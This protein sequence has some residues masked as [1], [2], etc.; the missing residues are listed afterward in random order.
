MRFS[1]K[2]ARLPASKLASTAKK[3]L[4]EL[5]RMRKVT[6]EDERASLLLS[7][8]ADVLRASRKTAAAV[9]RPDVLV[10]IG[11]GGS[12]LG[13]VAVQ[14]AVLGKGHNR[15]VLADMSASA[16]GAG[17]PQGPLVFYADTV[18]ADAIAAITPH[19]KGNVLLNI[20]S[21]SGGTTET[22]ANARILAKACRATIV[23]TTTKDS[24]LWN[25]AHVQGWRALEI[26]PSVGGR[27]SV[28]SNVGI[29]PLQLLGIDVVALRKGAAAMRKQCQLADVDKNPALASALA[30]YLHAQAGRNVTDLFLF[31]NDLESLGKWYRQL[32]G[33]SIGKEHDR[34]GNLVHAGITPTVS[35]GSTDLHSVGQLYLGGP[36]DK[37]VTFVRAQSRTQVMVPEGPEYGA[38]VSNLG[39]KSCQD[40][41][42]AILEGTKA[43]FDSARRPFLEI[44]MD[45]T[46]Q[47]IGAFL[48]FKMMEVMFLG[49]LYGVNPFDQP[50]VE[51]YKEH[52]RELL[53][54]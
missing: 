36:Q 23:A 51:S 28:L 39:G 15:C 32:L 45:K 48:Q 9:A 33:E 5:E 6:W 24:K 37:L 7:S 38:L 31:S 40:I 8:D 44:A 35:I 1:M 41:M 11:I 16:E 54:K 50:N 12:N 43:A 17:K 27:Y 3:I 47:D 52:T 4:P 30:Q 42:D 29:F 22:V 18:D 25:L 13:T 26:P 49:A 53:A 19:L 34:K 46:P 14:E 21:K 10:V 20:I 2:H